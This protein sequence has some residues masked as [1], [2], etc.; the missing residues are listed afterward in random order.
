MEIIVL[1]V[2]LIIMTTRIWSKP[3]GDRD[4]EVL[5]MYSFGETNIILVWL[6]RKC[7]RPIFV[8]SGCKVRSRNS[9]PPLRKNSHCWSTF[10]AISMS[11]KLFKNSFRT[12][13]RIIQEIRMTIMEISWSQYSDSHILRAN[14]RTRLGPSSGLGPTGIGGHLSLGRYIRL[15]V[16]LWINVI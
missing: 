9:A 4:H 11:N 12:Y 1:R 3:V 7:C 13:I 16:A 5:G 10:I 2:H 6:W 14:F 8:L 15:Y